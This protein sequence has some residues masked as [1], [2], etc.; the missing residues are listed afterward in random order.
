[1]QPGTHGDYAYKKYLAEEELKRGCREGNIPWTIF[2]P[3]FIYGK[4]NYAPRE[5]Y[6]FDLLGK[7]GKTIIL[8]DNDR[9]LFTFVAV[10]DVARA[11]IRC[12][13]NQDAYR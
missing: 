1:M 4:Y 12:M 5:S 6:F 9:A 10:W 2:R 8:P 13:G 3:T 11:I 7:D